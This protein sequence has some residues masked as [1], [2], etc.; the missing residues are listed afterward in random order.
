[1]EWHLTSTKKYLL[2]CISSSL[3]GSSWNSKTN[4]QPKDPT[5]D[6]SF[7]GIGDNEGTLHE[8]QIPFFALSR[9]HSTEFPENPYLVLCPYTP[10]KWK[11]CLQSFNNQGN[12][13]RRSL[14]YQLYFFFHSRYFPGILYFTI[15]IYGLQHL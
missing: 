3:Q 7:L 15:R 11:N 4:N 9:L 8:K 10:W 6:V 14:L 2:G 13:T 5:V 1:M 12:F